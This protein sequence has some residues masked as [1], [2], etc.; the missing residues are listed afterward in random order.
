MINCRACRFWVKDA[1]QPVLGEC[2]RHAPETVEWGKAF[3]ARIAWPLTQSS[4][5]CG[6][7]ESVRPLAAKGRR[8]KVTR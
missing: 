6:E 2:R 5:A 4:D 1:N 8:K 7:A 3:R